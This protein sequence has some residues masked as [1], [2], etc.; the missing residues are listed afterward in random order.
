MLLCLKEALELYLLV[1]SC[2]LFTAPMKIMV[3][4]R[5]ELEKAFAN[6]IMDNKSL[7]LVTCIIEI[8]EHISTAD[9]LIIINYMPMG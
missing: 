7:N 2:N 9:H 8:Q 5:K 1:F 6:R 4:Y 3:Y